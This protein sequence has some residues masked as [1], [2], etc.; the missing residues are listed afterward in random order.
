MR[1]GQLRQLVKIQE[2]TPTKDA[3]G[4]IVDTWSDVWSRRVQIMSLRGTELLDND[5]IRGTATFKITLR[6]LDGLTV[7][8]RIKYGSRIFEINHIGNFME[9][10]KWYEL[11]CT[12][13]TS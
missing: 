8:H 6:Y 11:M 1:P 12:E 10:N 13:L 5:V 7:L 9:R 2:N 3:Q 4:G